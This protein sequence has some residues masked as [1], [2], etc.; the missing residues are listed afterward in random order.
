MAAAILLQVAL[1]N[2]GWT[3]DAATAFTNEGFNDISDISLVTRDFLHQVCKKLRAGRAAAAAVDGNV[4]IPA[5]P[6]VNIPALQEFK[7]YGLHLWVT[8]K[9]RL[10]RVIVPAEF[11][12]A[13]GMDYTKRARDVVE[14]T[15]KKDDENVKQP[16]PF[17]GKTCEWQSF[18]KL[19]VN[20]LSSKKNRN[21]TPLGYVLRKNSEPSDLAGVFGTEHEKLVLTTP[22]EG[23]DYA[24]DNGMVW[25]TIQSLT[26]QGSAY[27]YI[28]CFARTR[29]GR[30][31]IQ[32]LIGR[33]E[34][35]AAMSRTKQAAYDEIHNASYTG[36][37]RNFTFENYIDKHAKAHQVL[38]ESG[39]DIGEDKKV[40]DFLR[41]L[42]DPSIRMNC[43]KTL[44][45]GNPDLRNDF[46]AC[47]EYLS[48]FVANATS[49]QSRLISAL[50]GGPL[51][52]GGPGGR[53]G[54]G[55]GRGR[56]GR[57]YDGGRFS[58]GRGGRGYRGGRG[59]GRGGNGRGNDQ[60]YGH[61]DQQWN[62][63][64]KAQ[65]DEIFQLRRQ[66]KDPKRGIGAVESDR[67]DH[68]VSAAAQQQNAG[69]QFALTNKKT[70]KN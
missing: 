11:T 60:L 68:A 70:K 64:S 34:G 12:A 6:P 51:P 66:Q 19:L 3:E 13:V 31:A 30:G 39:V 55:R 21:R 24:E 28:G 52:N 29:D 58:R 10:R 63:L 40:D 42:T 46:R 38:S 69:D 26:L 54:G 45:Y 18:Y 47:T 23:I 65:K 50:E 32:T 44:V 67:E 43:A 27:S 16:E 49:A 56:G 37:K 25:E 15:S 33:Y 35:T 5:I 14:A 17:S 62:A 1:S 36:E 48:S 22:H 59:G 9:V 7:L 20:Y 41:G 53:G 8:E 2:I 57:G 61:T 4:N